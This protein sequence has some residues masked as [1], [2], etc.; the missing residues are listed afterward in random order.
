MSLQEV[1]GNSMQDITSFSYLL[2]YINAKVNAAL[3]HSTTKAIA[4]LHLD[5]EIQ[6]PPVP[7]DLTTKY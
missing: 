1:L 6:T 5:Y 4:I 3:P 2:Q 7:N